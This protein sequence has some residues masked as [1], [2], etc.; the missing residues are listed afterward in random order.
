MNQ[1]ILFNDDLCFRPDKKY[2]QW[3]GILSGENITI[4][5]KCSVTPE[6][7]TTNYQFDW[8]LAIEDW[9]ID[10]EVENNQLTIAL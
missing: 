7:F 2:W 1:Q 8:E 9:L 3:S 4:V 10:N 5:I 6:T